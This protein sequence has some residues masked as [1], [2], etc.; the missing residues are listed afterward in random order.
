MTSPAMKFA[1]LAAAILLSIAANGQ[2]VANGEKLYEDFLCYSCH[3]YNGAIPRRPLVNDASGI[4]ASEVTFLAFLRL[5]GDMNPDTA[6]NSMPNYSEAALSDAQ[7]RDIY[8]YIR[9]MKDDPPEVA[10]NPVMQQILD[11]ARAKKPAANKE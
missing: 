1:L 5:R 10:D 8:A 9:T 6:T 7:A 3:G 11:A 4:M 2:D